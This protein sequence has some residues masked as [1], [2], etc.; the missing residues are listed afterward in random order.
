MLVCV[1]LLIMSHSTYQL[2][3]VEIPRTLALTTDTSVPEYFSRSYH[4]LPPRE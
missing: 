1:N 4:G 2:E 3:V